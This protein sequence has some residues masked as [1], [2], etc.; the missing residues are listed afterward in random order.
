[1]FVNNSKID[2]IV[3]KVQNRV[4][5]SIPLVEGTNNILFMYRDSFNNINS[6][7]FTM[8]V[9]ITSPNLVSIDGDKLI[10]RDGKFYIKVIDP[11]ID[12]IVF[13]E[14]V[15]NLLDSV[16]KDGKEF[17]FSLL[18]RDLNKIKI[19][20]YDKA[21]NS[22]TKEFS[23]EFSKSV[24]EINIDPLPQTTKSSNITVSI[25]LKG[26]F[27]RI[28]LYNQAIPLFSFDSPGDRISTNL[29][30]QSGKNLIRVEGFLLNG[31]VITKSTTVEYIPEI[32]QK[33][34]STPITFYQDTGSDIEK[35]KKEN[36]ELRRKIEELEEM[37]RK[38]SEGKTIEKVVVKE[39]RSVDS[40][41][42]LVKIPYNPSFDNFSKVAKKL[43]GS[44]SFSLYFYYIFKDTSISEL[45]SKK[46]YI[47][48]PNKKLMD[49][50]I[51][52]GDITA[53]EMISLIVE[54]WVSREIGQKESLDSIAK[55]LNMSLYG[56]RLM[57]KNGFLISY[58][59]G[60]DHV[61]ISVRK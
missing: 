46:G 36:A 35:L 23:L 42:S 2:V 5:S 7:S 3:D 21:G 29:Q 48:V 4:F 41:P 27:K 18:K 38:L 45:V 43:Y 61:S 26:S 13:S 40:I 11:Y 56:G 1:M 32:T 6:N 15:S 60:G 20:A 9:D 39:E 44:E 59:Y 55:R 47:I 10:E 14:S 25:G 52:T 8:I 22:T 53:F 17:S 33:Q 19:V 37:I 54:W 24:G 49:S 30:L 51:K 31:D 12:R 50:L 58:S 34:V 16:I 28:V 57:S